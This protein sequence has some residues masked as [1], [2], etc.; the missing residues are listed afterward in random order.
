MGVLIRSCDGTPICRILVR[1]AFF[2]VIWAPQ[3]MPCLIICHCCIAAIHGCVQML[4]LSYRSQ[5]V[6]SQFHAL[7]SSRVRRSQTLEI[8]LHRMRD[9]G[10]HVRIFICLDTPCVATTSRAERL[11]YVFT[12]LVGLLINGSGRCLV[13]STS[14]VLTRRAL[15]SGHQDGIAVNNE[16]AQEQPAAV[17]WMLLYAGLT[18]C[19]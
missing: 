16:H 3:D 7:E 18:F 10:M 13:H 1:G 6:A 5:Q 19:P 17:C 11:G 8:R 15:W 4:M 2:T 9:L 12:S 14:S